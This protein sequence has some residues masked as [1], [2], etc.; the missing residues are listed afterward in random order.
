MT[1]SLLGFD[2]EFFMCPEAGIRV[3]QSELAETKGILIRTSNIQDPFVKVH[4]GV[5]VASSSFPS[6]KPGCSSPT[7]F[8]GAIFSAGKDLEVDGGNSNLFAD[9][10][11]NLMETRNDRTPG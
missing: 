9:P 3:F 5:P 1:L 7:Q 11:C 8:G 6:A 4:G 10:I 2:G